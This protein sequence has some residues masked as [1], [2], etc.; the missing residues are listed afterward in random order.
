MR[1]AVITVWSMLCKINL[2]LLIV[3]VCKISHY[4]SLDECYRT[5]KRERLPLDMVL[6]KANRGRTVVLPCVLEKGQHSSHWAGEGGRTSS[7]PSP[8]TSHTYHQEVW[9]QMRLSRRCCEHWGLWCLQPASATFKLVLQPCKAQATSAQPPQLLTA[10]L[11]GPGGTPWPFT[12]TL[13]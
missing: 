6:S 8:T 4:R 7:P 2:Q 13:A 11:M 3:F 9:T 10:A 5:L 1:K 12:C